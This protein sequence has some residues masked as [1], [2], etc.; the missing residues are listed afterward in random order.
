MGSEMCIRDRPKIPTVIES[1]DISNLGE[2]SRVGGM[3][4]YRNGR[5]YKAGYRKFT[6][7]N[8]IGQNDYACMQEVLQRR[9]QRYLDGD[10]SFAPLP[11]LILLDGGKGHVHAVQQVL[12]SM[13]VSI[14]LYG[15]VKD[16][17]HRTRAITGDGG[18]I[19]ISSKRSAFTLVST[20]QDEVHRFAIGYMRTTSKKKS[21]TSSLTSIDGIGETR[22]KALLKFFK[23]IQRISDADVDE[24]MNVPTMTRPAAEAVYKHFHKRD[25]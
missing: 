17:K 13:N 25:N 11:D 9:I 24:L 4:V 6:I 10:E 20:I 7:K 16:D 18:E 12:D 21:F 19:S 14:P 22:A 1:Y 2:D 23:T 5:P 3:I 8:V 15:L